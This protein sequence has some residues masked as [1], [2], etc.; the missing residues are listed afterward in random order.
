GEGDA[1]EGAG[2]EVRRGG[3]GVEAEHGAAQVLVPDGE[4]F[5]A[6][7]GQDE[8]SRR[9]A[10]SFALALLEEVVGAPG[11]DAGEIGAARPCGGGAG[12]EERGDAQLGA[13]GEGEAV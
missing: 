8:Q 7:A 4:A 9:P 13:T 5:P 6:E 12:G 10:P 2:V 3:L 11:V 1:L